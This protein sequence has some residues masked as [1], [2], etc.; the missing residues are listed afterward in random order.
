M[1]EYNEILKRITALFINKEISDDEKLKMFDDL[2][3]EIEKFEQLIRDD[4]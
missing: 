4:E 2:H 1:D 3:Y